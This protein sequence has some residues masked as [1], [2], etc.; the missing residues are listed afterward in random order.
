[1]SA[2]ELAGDTAP[3]PLPTAAPAAPY[4]LADSPL[5]AC[6]GEHSLWGRVVT[7]PREIDAI[8]ARIAYQGRRRGGAR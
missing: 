5:W 6:A 8:R 7:D 4:E 3:A 2:V 1:M